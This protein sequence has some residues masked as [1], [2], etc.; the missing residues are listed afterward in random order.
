MCESDERL[1]GR[2]VALPI[3]N[4]FQILPPASARALSP[5]FYRASPAES[6]KLGLIGSSLEC[7]EIGRA[8]NC[9]E[10]NSLQD[11]INSHP[12]VIGNSLIGSTIDSRLT[13]S[14][15][16]L[17]AG[18]RLHLGIDGDWYDKLTIGQYFLK[19]KILKL[20]KKGPLP[21]PNPR[22]MLRLKRACSANWSNREI[23]T[24]DFEH[25]LVNL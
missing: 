17:H 22:R 11:S 23:L 12:A 19:R 4:G 6:Q 3:D 10:N 13:W 16:A 25:A 8:L 20:M 18:K 7:R 1:S 24:L 2:Q 14:D 15:A 21:L 5:Y 9:Q